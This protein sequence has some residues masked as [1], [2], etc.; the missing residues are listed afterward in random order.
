MLCQCKMVHQLRVKQCSPADERPW[1]LDSQANQWVLLLLFHYFR[2]RN[3][4][5]TLV[6]VCKFKTSIAD[7][8]EVTQ[9]LDHDEYMQKDL[10]QH[11]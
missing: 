4:K 1:L 10:E 2:L 11:R 6:L 8:I 7:H 5:K 9:E 3:L